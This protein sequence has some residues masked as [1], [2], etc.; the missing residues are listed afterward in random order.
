MMFG[1]VVGCLASILAII[2]VDSFKFLYQSIIGTVVQN[3]GSDLFNVWLL[4]LPAI[5]GLIVGGLLYSK[6]E[7]KLFTLADLIGRTQGQKP[8]LSWWETL[9]NALASIMSL[10]FGASVGPYAPIANMGGNIGALISRFGRADV[11][12]GVGCGV[13]AAISTAFNAPIAGIIFAHEVILRHYSLRAFAP[14]TVASSVGFFI[15]NYLFERPP[16]LEVHASRSIFAPEILGFVLVGII[17]AIVAVMFMR[18]ILYFM[19]VARRVSIPD[20]LKPAFAG[21]GIGL[22]AQWIPEILGVGTEVQ[23][24]ALIG[25][26]WDVAELLIILVAK[27]LATSLCIGF[28]FAG[29][30][31]SP[32]L[33]VGILLGAALGHVAALVYGEMSSGPVFYAVCGMVAVTSPII[34]APLTTILIVFELTRDYEL[35]TA[36]MVSVVFSNVVAY[37]L[38]GRSLFDVQLNQQGMDLSMGRDQVVLQQTGIQ[39]FVQTDFVN[40][41]PENSI[42][43]AHASMMDIQITE[44]YVVDDLGKLV[45]KLDLHAIIVLLEAGETSLSVADAMKP[46]DICFQQ[47]DSV[48]SAMQKIRDINVESIPIVDQRGYFIGIIRPSSIV[49]AYLR[50]VQSLRAEEHA[51]N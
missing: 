32:S 36:A 34:G 26:Q 28:G 21:L 35:T 31:F 11:S 43:K 50:I 3:S 1:V 41:S 44:G 29:G 20:F 39:E 46:I 16:L 17:G 24:A 38:F 15:S 45:G 13:A 27:I 25:Q 42:Q 8:M 51:A 48:W 12:L 14:I 49:D 33:L 23:K 9:R 5:G 10:S 19:N 7:S 47:S 2:F 4:L 6:K 37:R 30:V 18:S 40:F 22:M